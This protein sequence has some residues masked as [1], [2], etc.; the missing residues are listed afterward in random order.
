MSSAEISLTLGALEV[1]ILLS[2]TAYGIMAAQAYSYFQH[3]WEGDSRIIKTIVSSVNR[4]CSVMAFNLL[5]RF[6][7]P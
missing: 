1:G 5:V 6:R 2:M 7:C 3:S 4:L